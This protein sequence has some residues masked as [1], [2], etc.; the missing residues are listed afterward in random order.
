[1]NWFWG[2]GRYRFNLVVM[3]FATGCLAA[4]PESAVMLLPG[5]GL[6]VGLVMRYRHWL[7]AGRPPSVEDDP[8]ELD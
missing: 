2:D 3:A 7:V 8:A 1:M 6:L 4:V 5:I